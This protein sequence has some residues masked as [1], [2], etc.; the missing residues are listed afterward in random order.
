VDGGRGHG[1][2]SGEVKVNNIFGRRY[3]FAM[4]G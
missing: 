2:G 1:K 3:S 4:S